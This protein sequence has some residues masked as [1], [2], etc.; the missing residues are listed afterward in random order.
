MMEAK[1]YEGEITPSLEGAVENQSNGNTEYI[2]Y[3]HGSMAIIK[4]LLVFF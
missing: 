1:Y 4:P 2:R 3:W